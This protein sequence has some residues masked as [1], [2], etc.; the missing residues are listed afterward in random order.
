MQFQKVSLSE[1][2]NIAI[3]L[4][5]VETVKKVK[6]IKNSFKTDGDFIFPK[7]FLNGCNRWYSLNY[8][9]C[10]FTA[11]CIESFC[12]LHSL[13]TICNSRAE[14]EYPYIRKHWL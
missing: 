13:L 14:K 9:S 8:S 10:L 6:N 7:T 5:Y 4:E 12:I 2:Y 3:A 1:P 11:Q